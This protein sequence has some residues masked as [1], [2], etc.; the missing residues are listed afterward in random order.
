MDEHAVV[1]GA[2]MGGLLGACALAEHFERVTVIERDALTGPVEP[3]RAIP[4]GRHAHALL[5]R[6]RGCLEE[7]L[8]G[9]GADLLAAGA[10]PYRALRQL[11]FAPGGHELARGD[12]GRD[13]LVASR[14][15]IETEVRRRVQ[16][17]E[18]V[19]IVDRCDAVG[20]LATP[21]GARVTGVRTLR[22]APGSAEE[23]R[24]AEVVLAATGRGGRLPAWLETLGCPR[25]AE[26]RIAVDFAYASCG[27]ELE[28]DALGGDRLVLIAST[29][30]VP[31]TLALFAQEHG[32]WLLT[33]GGYAGHHPPRDRAG[34]LAF[35]ASVA[36][37]D[38]NRAIRAARPLDD[39]VAH[40]FPANVRR[41]YTR[42][43]HGLLPIGDALCAFNPIYGQGMTVAAAE[44]LAL[45]DALRAGGR[46]VGRRYL[47]AA[48]EIVA[49]AWSLAAGADMDQPLVPGRRPLR[50]R[51]TN[52]YLR[53]V[54]A[55][56]ARD[57]E[58]A[59]GL[60]R[61]SGL[62]DPPAALL[63]PAVVRRALRPR[64]AARPVAAPDAR[65][66]AVDGVTTPLL[67]AGP[68]GAREA[69]VFIHGNPGSS[70]DW[71]PLIAAVGASR[72]AVAWDAPGF[73]RAATPAGFPQTIDA[74]A[75]FIGHALE[76][77]GIE[78]ALLVA[79][80]FGGP[81]GLEWAAREPERFAGVVLLGTGVFP[82]YRWHALARLWRTRGLGELFMATTTRPGFRLLLRRGQPRPLPRAFLDRMYDDFDRDTR[83]AVLALYRSVGDVSAESVRRAAALRPLDRPA[84]VLWGRRDPYLPAA[85]AERQREAFPHAT[86]RILER[87]AHWPFADDPATVTQEIV[88]FAD[89]HAG[90]EPAPGLRLAA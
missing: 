62:L 12:V 25:P 53:R 46:D 32:R 77:Q 68:A 61:V 13:S 64:A 81:W 19:E 1:I 24:P 90:R 36:P 28:P 3:R 58:L 30:A 23:I 35:A 34:F 79:H 39:I 44:A 20:L 80:D 86:V 18:G 42:L 47:Q 41:R 85:L 55:A 88:A 76:A 37:P 69:V 59:T 16:A 2:G 50:V 7:L 49:Q 9:I 71:A 6:G 26:E 29:P 8:P 48:D 82:G 21:D 15:L 87:C 4:Q 78:R 38:V 52:A 57:P 43:P 10:Q 72:R 27:L 73:G 83:R 54:F 14:P 5:A 74:H 17:L 75:T 22:R 11:R 31:R 63:R 84:L 65:R 70:A 60:I 66:L 51:A 33:L 56:A 67:E 89:R 45:R 40:R